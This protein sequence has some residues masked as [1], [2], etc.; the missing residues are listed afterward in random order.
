MEG[1]SYQDLQARISALIRQND[2]AGRMTAKVLGELREARDEVD[3]L[4]GL[5]ILL[6]EEREAWRKGALKRDERIA[7]LAADLT[8]ARTV[9]ECV[10]EDYANADASVRQRWHSTTGS[11]GWGVGQ[12]S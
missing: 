3:R 8:H 7:T 11:D 1:E 9:A 2:A 10:Y 12:R 4:E 5:R 6:I